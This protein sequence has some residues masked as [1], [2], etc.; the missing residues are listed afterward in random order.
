[1]NRTNIWGKNMPEEKEEIVAPKETPLTGFNR[2]LEILAGKISRKLALIGLA[3]VL[4]YLLAI[5]PTVTSLLTIVAILSGLAIFGVLLQ[6]VI[7]YV[8]IVRRDKRNR[9]TREDSSSR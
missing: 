3:M 5:T 9:E 7:D 1:M 8:N 4:I 2:V 6:F